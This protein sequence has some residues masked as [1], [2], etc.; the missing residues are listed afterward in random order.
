[1]VEKEVNVFGI[2]VSRL[3][4]NGK[5]DMTKFEQNMPR[6]LP[7]IWERVIATR[8]DLKQEAACVMLHKLKR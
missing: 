2:R 3:H 6:K 7:S 1:M 5:S 8:H 4:N